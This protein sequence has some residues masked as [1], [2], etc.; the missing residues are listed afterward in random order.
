MP[1]EV[2]VKLSTITTLSLSAIIWIEFLAY[3]APPFA[4]AK[5]PVVVAELP[6]NDVLVSVNLQLLYIAPPNAS[7]C[8]SVEL[9]SKLTL[10]ML[11]SASDA[12]L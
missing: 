2:L 5:S 11:I 6:I 8:D 7:V 3:I 9:L 12:V 1:S 4:P 10:F